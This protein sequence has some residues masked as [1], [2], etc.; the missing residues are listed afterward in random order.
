MYLGGHAGRNGQNRDAKECPNNTLQE[1][2]LAIMLESFYS[3]YLESRVGYSACIAELDFVS[4]CIHDDIQFSNFKDSEICE[5]MAI[6]KLY[7]D[8]EWGRTYSR[9]L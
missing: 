7:N 2:R 4:D 8:K 9:Q 5:E 3:A 6:F 1:G